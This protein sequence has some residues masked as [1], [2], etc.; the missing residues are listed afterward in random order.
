MGYDVTTETLGL[1]AQF[2]AMLERV[3]E[4][5]AERVLGKYT[6]P[7]QSELLTTAELADALKMSEDMIRYWVRMHDCPHV[8]AGKKKLRFRLAEVL[9][10]LEER[11]GA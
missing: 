7:A 4:R 5:V 3:L 1:L 9:A 2:E 8:R 6:Q 11:D 10:W